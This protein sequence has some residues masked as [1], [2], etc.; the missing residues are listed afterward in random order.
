MLRSVLHSLYGRLRCSGGCLRL[1]SCFQP[2]SSLSR[3]PTRSSLSRLSGDLSLRRSDDL[4]RRSRELSLLRSGDLLGSVSLSSDRRRRLGDRSRRLSGERSLLL[5]C[6][7][8]LS[9]VLS[10]LLVPS[11]RFSGDLLFCPFTTALSGCLSCLLSGD[12]SVLLPGTWSLVL[13]VPFQ[14]WCSLG[15]LLNSLLPFRSLT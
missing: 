11:L 13:E 8:R 3:W 15:C 2:G 1:G 7:S 6:R 9:K 10:A 4:A 12:L 5:S 14:V